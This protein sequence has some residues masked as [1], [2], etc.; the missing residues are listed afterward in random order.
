MCPTPYTRISCGEWRKSA[1]GRAWVVSRGTYVGGLSRDLATS[2][3]ELARLEMKFDLQVFQTNLPVQLP[4]PRDVWG[5]AIR[6]A[7]L[8]GRTLRPSGARPATR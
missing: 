7:R 2:R 6:S 3:I 8:D 5:T 4:L 1:V